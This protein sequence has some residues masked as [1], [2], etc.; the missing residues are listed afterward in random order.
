MSSNF[1]NQLRLTEWKEIAFIFNWQIIIFIGEKWWTKE[2]LNLPADEI[3]DFILESHKGLSVLQESDFQDNLD[4]TDLSS[5]FSESQKREKNVDSQADPAIPK[6]SWENRRTANP[7]THPRQTKMNKKNST[8]YN[9]KWTQAKPTPAMRTLEFV[10][11]KRKRS[12]TEHVTR[13]K[14]FLHINLFLH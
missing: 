3:S 14:P 4:A 1:C 7:N 13:D 9:M 12:V 5:D 2:R 11:N 8:Q 10:G 6:P